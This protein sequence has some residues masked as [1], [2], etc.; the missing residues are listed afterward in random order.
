MVPPV[1][2]SASPDPHASPES[3]TQ[4]RTS[5][6]TP[7]RR[8]N[9]LDETTAGVILLAAAVVAL[10]WANSPWR[11]T[12]HAIAGTYVG[13]EGLGLRM[14]LSHWAADGLLAI[15]FV[16][17]GLELK[18]EFVSGSLR[19][20]KRAAVPMIAAFLG[21]VVPAS[22]YAIVQVVT[23]S[24]ATSGWAIPTATD[25]AF[26]VALLGILGKGLPPG[27]RVFLLT[28]A[29]VDDLLA[30]TVIA[31]FY[32]ESI[33]LI[34]LAGSAACIAVFAVLVQRR[35]RSPFV[36]IPLGVLAWALMYGSGVHA[37]VAGVVLGMVVPARR[38]SDEHHP[39]THAFAVRI[40]P[41]SKAVALPVFAFFAAGVTV[42][43][44]GGVGQML[45]HPVSIGVILGLVMGKPIG[46]WG[47]TWLLT[48]LTPLRL[49]GGVDMPD[50]LGVSMLAGIGFT[51]SLL[52]AN[53]S[54]AGG[55]PVSDYARLS[56]IL[57][58]VI[59]ALLAA[60]VLRIRVRTLV[61]G[62]PKHTR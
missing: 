24:G 40:D 15:F 5:A 52:I 32:T 34:H 8:R 51:V 38:R 29:V 27:A 9:T 26:A 21:M 2:S 55:D 25:I 61:R 12:Y 57:G 44:G 41:I 14:S 4:R 33:S 62:N 54:F 18:Q 45:G 46:I 59:A 53:L 10:A 58:S 22:I 48:R 56:V 7:R 6:R 42:V 3:T 37:T 31:V 49:P 30:I 13:P 36:L 20:P 17:V 19:D 16:V 43:G 39:M 35:V 23:D 47:G 50:L 11:E 60:V 1:P 28:L